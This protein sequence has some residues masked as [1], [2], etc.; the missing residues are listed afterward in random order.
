MISVIAS[1]YADA[2]FQ[3][4]E[5]ENSSNVL[6]KELNKVLDTINSSDELKRALRSPLVAKKEKKDLINMIFTDEISKNTKNFLKIL[7]DKDRIVCLNDIRDSYKQMINEKNN[8]LEGKAISAIAMSENEINQLQSKLSSK[9]NK[10]VVL[11]NI[12]DETVL[13]GVLVRLGNEEI[14][15]TVKTRLSNLKEQLSQVI[16]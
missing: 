1:R 10:N 15:G 4:G 12:V 13:G 14:D 16:S 2:L 9:Y 11:K 6:Y 8:I 5:E 3:I 7:V